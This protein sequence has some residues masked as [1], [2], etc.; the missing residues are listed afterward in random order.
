MEDSE[1]MSPDGF[2]VQEFTVNILPAI[3][4]KDELNK[5]QNIDYLKSENERVWKETYESFYKKKL[6]YDN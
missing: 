2:P 3:Y 1:I 4:P 5:S 6:K